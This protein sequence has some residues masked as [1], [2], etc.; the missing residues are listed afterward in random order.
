MLIFRRMTLQ[1]F[2]SLCRIFPFSNDCSAMMYLFTE[3]NFH[4]GT[5]TTSLCLKGTGQRE[6]KAST[7]IKIYQ[8]QGSM[9]LNVYIDLSNILYR[10]DDPG[11]VADFLFLI[12][13]SAMVSHAEWV[14]NEHV[15]FWGHIQIC[16]HIKRGQ[17]MLTIHDIFILYQKNLW[18]APVLSL[19]I[20]YDSP[21]CAKWWVQRVW[22]CISVWKIYQHHERYV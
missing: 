15:I 10:N 2:T 1:L 4:K 18:S 21:L 7:H 22:W 9:L 19:K 5:T 11:Q 20:F 13:D 12:L 8:R 14:V 17:N 16:W 3:Y 6:G